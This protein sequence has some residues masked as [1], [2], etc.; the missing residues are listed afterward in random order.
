MKISSYLFYQP[1][2]ATPESFGCGALVCGQLNGE[3]IFSSLGEVVF[4]GAQISAPLLRATPAVQE[5]GTRHK[6]LF[7]RPWL[8]GNSIS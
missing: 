5:M 7:L 1:Y 2:E 8:Y 4:T 3:M 6:P